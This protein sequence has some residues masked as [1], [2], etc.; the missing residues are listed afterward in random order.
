M[1]KLK[2]KKGFTL[3]E[4][5]IT[6]GVAAIILTP[7]SLFVSSSLRSANQAQ[8]EI[9]SMQDAQQIYLIINET[10]RRS[11]AS[12]VEIIENYCN[13]GVRVLKIRDSV[14]FSNDE[15][16]VK[17]DYNSSKENAGS[18]YIISKYVIGNDFTRI[19]DVIT[20]T[21]TNDIDGDGNRIDHY[22]TKFYLRH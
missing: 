19:D 1:K 7:F 2:S 20:M 17:Q 14:Y 3:V 9:D 22:E 10:I 15:G 21:I 8:R 13:L 18:E 6:I 16:F 11:S 4:L 12:E 5:I